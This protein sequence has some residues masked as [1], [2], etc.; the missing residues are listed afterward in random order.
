MTQVEQIEARMKD[1]KEEATKLSLNISKLASILSLDSFI[2]TDLSC[3]IHIVRFFLSLSHV[4]WAIALPT[5]N[6][7]PLFPE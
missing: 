6:A 5:L 2:A 3:P 7:C 1:K 4:N